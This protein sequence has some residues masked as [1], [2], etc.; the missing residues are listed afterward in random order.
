MLNDNKNTC[1]CKER[2]NKNSISKPRHHL[3]CERENLG[4]EELMG[5]GQMVAF[6]VLGVLV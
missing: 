2:E 3:W 5:G 6:G 1:F 4:T